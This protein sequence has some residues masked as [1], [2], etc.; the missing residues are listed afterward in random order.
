M[1]AS[2]DELVL[3]TS[4]A[5]HPCGWLEIK[6]LACGETVSLLD[7]CTKAEHKPSIFLQY[8]DGNY[9]LKRM[10]NYYYHVQGQ[11]YITATQWCNFVVWTPNY[12]TLECVW[13]NSVLWSKKMY[14]HLKLFYMNSLLPELASPYY[15]AQPIQESVPF[16]LL[17]IACNN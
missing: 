4:E 13:F 7:L 8:R 1:G 15:P 11:L 5:D 17:K 6:C 16:I 2:P 9:H 14:P 10:H 3:D 12:T